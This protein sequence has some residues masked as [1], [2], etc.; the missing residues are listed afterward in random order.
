MVLLGTGVDIGAGEE[1]VRQARERLAAGPGEILGTE[2]ARRTTIA[3]N[4]GFEVYRPEDV[5]GSHYE[6]LRGAKRRYDP[7]NKLKGPIRA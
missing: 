6:R 4:A 5:Y 3:P 2:G 7:E 1:E